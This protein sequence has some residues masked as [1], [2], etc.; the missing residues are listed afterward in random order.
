[1]PNTMAES[2]ERIYT[3]KE[4]SKEVDITVQTLA[5]ACRDG[6][7]RAMQ[8]SDSSRHGFHWMVAEYDLIDWMDKRGMK[9]RGRKPKP[10]TPEEQKSS[11]WQL[12]YST[13]Y[14][15]GYQKALRKA[16]KAVKL[17]GEPDNG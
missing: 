3:L 17:L 6:D 13:G 11:T 9:K 12:A 15:A 5:K 1:M 2:N 16:I 10:P 8:I 14:A 7:L 4:A